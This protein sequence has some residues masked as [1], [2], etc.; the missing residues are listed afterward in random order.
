MAAAFLPK[1]VKTYLHEP[2]WPSHTCTLPPPDDAVPDKDTTT[3]CALLADTT[4]DEAARADFSSSWCVVEEFEVRLGMRSPIR[5]AI[6]GD[7][8]RSMR[9]VEELQ[10]AIVASTSVQLRLFDSRLAS[11]SYRLAALDAD[12]SPTPLGPSDP[13]DQLST[14]RL[15]LMPN[16]VSAR[17]KSGIG[18]RTPVTLAAISG[19]DRKARTAQ[20]AR[21]K[22]AAQRMAAY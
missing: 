14:R 3:T 20:L 12:G 13:I 16:I 1:A 17:E 22:R 21:M 15:E 10:R 19:A 11:T 18:A 9:S 5:V 6:A 2:L 7:E 8:L 4:T